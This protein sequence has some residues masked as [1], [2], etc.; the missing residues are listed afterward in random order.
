GRP[1]RPE[2]EH[3]LQHQ[4]EVSVGRHPL[5]QGGS[6][7]HALAVRHPRLFRHFINLYPCFRGTGG[8]VTHIAPDWSEMRVRLRLNWRTRNY[9]G[10]LF[11][12]SLY[13]ALD[14]H[15]MFMLMHRL[16]PAYLV[17]DK[18]ASIRFRRPGRSALTAVCRMPDEEVAEV[19]RLLETQPKVDRTYTV[20]L[21]D[22][23][24]VVHASVEKVVN[25][26]LAPVG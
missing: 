14:P 9:V 18:A 22:A 7:L 15:F 25:V 24:G 1:G 16:G 13:A 8:R 17:W 20:D 26:R 11:G 6:R 10:T 12:G 21:V 2:A 23:A 19:R 3:G 5:R 4:V